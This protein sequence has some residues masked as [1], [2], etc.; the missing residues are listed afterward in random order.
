MSSAALLNQA[1]DGKDKTV[2]KCVVWDLDETLWS[3]VLLEAK[4][5]KLRENVIEIVKE[6]DRRGILQSVASKNDEETAREVLRKFGLEEYFLYPQINWN[7]KTES[8]RSIAGLLNIGLDTVALIDDQPFERDEVNFSLP[9]VLCLDA[10]CLDRL[11]EMQEFK[12]SFITEDSQMRRQMYLA[13]HERNRVEL[14]FVG[15]KEDFLATLGM[16]F[17]IGEAREDELKRAQELTNRTNQLNTTG[18]SYSYEQLNRFRESTQHKLFITS[19]SDKYGSYGKI[20]LALVECV[21][22]AWIIKLLL[23]SCRVMSRGVGTILLN[24]IMHLAREAS[25]R[26]LAEFI[27]NERNRMMYVTF[28]LAGFK[29]R[30]GPGSLL[31]ND[32]ERIS[33]LPGYIDVRV[34]H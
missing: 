6:L 26:L 27:A 20:G 24:H 21:R 32:L 15:P 29:E 9:E 31:E 16:V 18:Y 28:K 5:V 3:G 4:E 7:S 30:S 2:V 1:Q 12:P 10:A 14:E 13:D 22:E 23:M 25:V 17:T 8:V 33:P 34:R 19:L 11:L